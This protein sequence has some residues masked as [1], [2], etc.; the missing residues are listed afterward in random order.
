MK[1]SNE[2]SGLFVLQTRCQSELVEDRL[3]QIHLEQAQCD[4][5]FIVYYL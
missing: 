4:R 2:S 1:V 5:L 3:T